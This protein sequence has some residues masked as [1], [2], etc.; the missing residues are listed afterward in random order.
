MYGAYLEADVYT[1]TYTFI[2]IES[3]DMLNVYPSFFTF[4]AGSEHN[5]LLS[6][7]SSLTIWIRSVTNPYV[8]VI[9]VSLKNPIHRI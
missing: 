9:D 6:T 7:T 4:Q 3:L 2:K 5:G 1:F 8:S